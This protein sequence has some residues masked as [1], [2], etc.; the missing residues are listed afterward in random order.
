MCS[1]VDGPPVSRPLLDSAELERVVAFHGHLCPGLAIGVQAAAIALRE[2]G[3]HSKDEE[4]VAVVETDMCAVDAIQFL[5]GCTFGKGNLVHADYGKNSYTFFRR[6]D[7]KAI[8]IA[9]RP[10]AWPR[11]PEHQEL[12]AKIRAGEATPAE[13]ERFQQLH[14]SQSH[15]VLDLDPDQL[16]TVTQIDAE[17]PRRARIH[18]SIT[19]ARCGEGA[20][21][22]R[23]RR[24][25]GEELCQPCFDAA[26]A[27]H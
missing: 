18:T 21:E 5:T 25:G 15:A 13:R 23:V 19:C 26:L 17:P 20:M 2:I 9:S 10:D 6:S 7:G 4:V 27:A 16:F 1:E 11:D 3:P 8:R 14:V 24:F 12:F 22:T